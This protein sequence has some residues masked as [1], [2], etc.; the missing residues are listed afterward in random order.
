[1][2][3]M[4]TGC[5]VRDGRPRTCRPLSLARRRQWPF[6]RL[7]V[8]AV[9]ALALISVVLDDADARSFRVELTHG[10]VEAEFTPP[11]RPCGLLKCPLVVL[12]PGF[13]VP[14]AVWN[15]NVSALAAAGFPV[16]RFDLYGRGRSARPRVDYR[17]ELFAEQVWELVTAPELRRELRPPNRIHM[18]ASS[19]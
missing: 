14:M 13:A 1:M 11:S 5:I 16:L 3:S 9:L 7:R 17:P 18:V 10:A 6:G 8:A 15:A 4:R 12:V 2:S 19:M